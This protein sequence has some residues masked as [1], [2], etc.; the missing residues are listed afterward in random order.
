M[1]A[2]EVTGF[3]DPR[4]FSIQYVVADPASRQCAVVDPVLD[5][6]ERSGCTATRNADAILA[7]VER[8][9]LKIA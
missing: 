9:G 5:F 6:E 7:H 3:Y 8:R 1:P 2:P 4:T